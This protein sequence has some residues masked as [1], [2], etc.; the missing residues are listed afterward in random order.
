[1]HGHREAVCPGGVFDASD[2]K[3]ADRCAQTLMQRGRYDRRPW[4]YRTT[5]VA[6]TKRQRFL[7]RAFDVVFS[8]AALLFTGP[9]YPLIMLAI[10]LEDGRPFFFVHHRQTLGGRDFACLKFRTMTRDAESLR[11]ALA[12][13]NLCDGPQFHINDDPRLLRIGRLLRRL[14]LDELPQFVNVLLGDMSVIG[15]RPSPDNENQCCPAWREARLSVKPGIT[16]LWQVDRTRAPDSDFQE[17]IRHD[18]EYVDRRSLGLDAL[19]LCKTVEDV[20]RRAAGHVPAF[21]RDRR[22]A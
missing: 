17:W 11:G 16:G 22:A 18:L 1:V 9:F 13:R 3:D 2:P 8:A 7:R 19:I 6:G 5:P 21:D 15:P 10:W 20:C 14:H 4:V 12:G